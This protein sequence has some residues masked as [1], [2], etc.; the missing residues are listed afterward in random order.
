MG[1]GGDNTAIIIFSVAE[2][3]TQLCETHPAES[4]DVLNTAI[5]S[6]SEAFDVQVGDPAQVKERS[7]KPHG[8]G[9]IFA[10]GATALG[11]KTTAEQLKEVE[12]NPSF[13]AFLKAVSAKGFF[14][15]V[16]VG[17]PEYDERM[18]KLVAKF[19]ART[20][21]AAASTPTPDAV[22]ATAPESAGPDTTAPVAEPV[23]ASSARSA[24]GKGGSAKAEKEKEAESKKMAGNELL[25]SNDYEGAV[26]LYTEAFELSPQGPNSHIYLCNRAAALCHLC[27]Y[28]DAVVDCQES[29]DLNSSYSK[30]Y[31]RLGYAFFQLEDYEASAKAYRKSLELDPGN[32]ANRQ[33]LRKAEAKMGK[34]ERESDLSREA[35]DSAGAGGM[36]DMSG[37]ASMMG[38]AGGAGGLA[39][40]MQNKDL[41]AQAQNLMQNPN[42]MA[43]AQKMMQ[44]PV[45]PS[46]THTLLVLCS[47]DCRYC[48]N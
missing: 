14:K 47:L 18:T 30:A 39:N 19:R 41:M 34:D 38:G 37:L 27:K 28:G 23:A 10:A 36:P 4:R 15:G 7:L 16:T 9:E 43:Q 45:S 8:L 21:P 25:K 32:A 20:Q 6:L 44:N 1:G 26:K 2:Y 42:M 17:T 3:L 35:S 12:S 31:T 33:S 11:A 24:G 29:I 40:L 5:R 48:W 46:L 13:G 22:P